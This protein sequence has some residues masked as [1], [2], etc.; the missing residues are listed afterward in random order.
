MA[1]LAEL[2]EFL[3]SVPGSNDTRVGK[4]VD[5]FADPDVDISMPGDLIGADADFLVKCMKGAISGGHGVFACFAFALRWPLVGICQPYGQA[6]S[7]GGVVAIRA[8][9]FVGRS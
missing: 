7:L 5:L 9:P 3:V 6:Q 2:R 4:A 8:S 1:L